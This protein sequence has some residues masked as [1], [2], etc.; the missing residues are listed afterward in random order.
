MGN[1]LAYEIVPLLSEVQIFR[2]LMKWRGLISGIN[3]NIGVNQALT[4]VSINFP[5][6]KEALFLWIFRA[7]KSF[8]KPDNIVAVGL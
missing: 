3:Q 5:A 6:I 2:G 7:G 1:S 4:I 8:V